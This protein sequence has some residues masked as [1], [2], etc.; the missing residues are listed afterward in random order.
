MTST[1]PNAVGWYRVT[2]FFY[3]KIH[4]DDVDSYDEWV[5]FRDD[6][7]RLD[8]LEGHARVTGILYSEDTKA[9]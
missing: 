1:K 2:L 6:D 3:N 5:E 7:W 4:E 9:H 8:E